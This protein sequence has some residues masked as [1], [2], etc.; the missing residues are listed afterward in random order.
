MATRKR[1]DSGSR[2]QLKEKVVQIYESFFQGEDLSINNPNFWDEFFLLKPKVVNFESEVDR[3]SPEQLLKLKDNINVLFSQC[4][5]MLSHEHNIRVVY[6]MQTL[7]A[8]MS[9]VLRKQ[10]EHGVDIITVLIGLDGVEKQMKHVIRHCNNFLAGE[11]P[12]SLKSLCLKLVLIIVTGLDNINQNNILEYMMLNNMFETLIKL[13]T[14]PKSRL[15]HGS[16]V[17][18]LIT[19][20]VN[21]RKHEAVN[22]YI[23]K[24]SI[25]DNELALS[26]YAQ[27]IRRCLD[28]VPHESYEQGKCIIT[29][30]LMS[31]MSKFLMSHM[32]KVS[33]RVPHESYEQGTCIITEF[34][35]SHTSKQTLVAVLI[36]LITEFLMSHTSKQTLVAVLIDLITEFLMSHM[37]KQTLVAVLIDLITEFLMSH[38]SKQT[39]VAVLIDLITEFLMS[40]MSKQTLVAV[41]IDLITEFLMSHMSKVINIFNLFITYGDT[42]IVMQDTRTE[43]SV[44]TAKLCLL[45][46]SCIAEDPTASSLMHDPRSYLWTYALNVHTAKLCLLILSCIAEDPTASSLMH[47]PSLRYRVPLA[48]VPMRHR[49]LPLDVCPQQ[50]LVAVLIDLITEFLMSHM[51]KVSVSLQSSNET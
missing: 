38:M 49:K 15:E 29:E 33:V 11:Q 47:D 25:V 31:H 16:D 34:L 18:L 17:I 46:L 39:L 45:I 27:V 5:S 40:H 21:Y 19:L 36:D 32:S 8:L 37:S 44:H 13:L 3:L 48:R 6:A 43:T 14:E 20:L 26:G 22:P 2:R 12:A 51:S 1:S 9:S 41:L 4:V 42:S 50:T 23:V 10:R 7:C 30:F 24:L 28:G 35:M